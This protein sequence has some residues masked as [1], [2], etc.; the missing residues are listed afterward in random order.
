MPTYVWWPVHYPCDF[1]IWVHFLNVVKHWMICSPINY[2]KN[3]L[4]KIPKESINSLCI[5]TSKE[6]HSWNPLNSA[7]EEDNI[8]WACL[9]KHAAAYL[10]YLT[11]DCNLN[12]N[13]T[14]RYTSPLNR[15]LLIN[16]QDQ[17][18][19]CKKVITKFFINHFINTLHWAL[20]FHNAVVKIKTW[21]TEK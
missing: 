15:L 16:A 5:D 13:Q 8:F 2:L 10:I 11:F 12:F 3:T 20:I 18:L 6:K 17:R 19:W 4:R 7:L 9:F 21:R 14:I 1:L